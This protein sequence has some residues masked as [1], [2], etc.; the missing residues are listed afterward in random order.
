M[1]GP[2]R[3]YRRHRHC[4]DPHCDDSHCDDSHCDDSH[5]D[6]PRGHDR[7]ADGPIVWLELVWLFLVVINPFLTRVLTEGRADLVRFAPYAVAQ[8]VQLGTFAVLV[9]VVSRR[10]WFAP[11]TPTGLTHRGWMGSLIPASG[12]VLSLPAFPASVSGRSRCGRCCRSSAAG[13]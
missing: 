9:A 11:G 4:D 7:R 10:G 12:F 3:G 8:A 5:C 13:S 1:S 6:D 2:L